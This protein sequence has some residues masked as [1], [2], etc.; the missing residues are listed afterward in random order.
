MFQIDD[1]VIHITSGICQVTKIAPLE[2]SGADRNRDYYYLV[3]LNSK[4]SKVF[5]PVDNDSAIRSVITSDEAQKLISDIPSIEELIIDNEKLRE[6]RYKEVIKSCDLRD[7]VG[8]IKN[9]SVRRMKRLEEG[10]KSTATDDKYF[11]IA[12]ENL[13]SELAFALGKEKAELKEIVST[14]LLNA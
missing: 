11:K 1:Y 7:L 5:V 12:E 9:L 8:V 13:F 10:K 3:P 2:I 14:T 4:G 6:A